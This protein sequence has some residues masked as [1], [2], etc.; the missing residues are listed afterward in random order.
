MFVPGSGLSIS[1][2]QTNPEKKTHKKYHN[3]HHAKWNWENRHTTR[4]RFYLFIYLF[5]WPYLSSNSCLLFVALE[6]ISQIHRYLYMWWSG[7]IR[8]WCA[9]FYQ[10]RVLHMI[11]KYLFREHFIYTFNENAQLFRALSYAAEKSGSGS[12]VQEICDLFWIDLIS[13]LLLDSV[14]FVL[15]SAIK[16]PSAIWLFSDR[17]NQFSSSAAPHKLQKHLKLATLF[18]SFCPSYSYFSE[19]IAARRS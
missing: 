4:Q 8:W 10:R 2:R 16:W 9:C 17:L 1:R 18:H 7:P 11:L 5:S 14:C 3:A 13:L 15:C 19:L 12:S 6:R